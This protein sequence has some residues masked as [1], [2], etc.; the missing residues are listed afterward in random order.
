M[1]TWRDRLRFLA[2]A[3]AYVAAFALASR[4][5]R[6]SVWSP[7]FVFLAMICFLGLA[8]MARPVV[9]IRMPRALRRIRAWEVDKGLY[10]RLGVPAFGRLL[11]LTSL[12]LLNTDVYLDGGTRD[13]ARLSAQLEAAEASHVWDAVLVVPY[14]VHAGVTGA[15]MTLL[16]FTLA[17]VVVNAYPVMHLRLT[18]DRVGRLAARNGRRWDRCVTR[19]ERCSLSPRAR[20]T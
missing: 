5:V 2:V 11:R 15:W 12:R 13:V 3:A 19:A 17:Q 18:R 9:D 14:M 1:G 10:R 16:G 4:V 6:F 7:P 20:C 8:A